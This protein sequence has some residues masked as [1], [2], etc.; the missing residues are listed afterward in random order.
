MH[1]IYGT[2]NNYPEKYALL[3]VSIHASFRGRK[4][5]KYIALNI[6][7]P[8]NNTFMNKSQDNHITLSFFLL[9]FFYGVECVAPSSISCL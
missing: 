5:S 3:V 4:I 6:F 9:F 7:F 2:H 8:C 1:M